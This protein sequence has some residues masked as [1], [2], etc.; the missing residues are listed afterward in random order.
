MM[1]LLPP[2]PSR[3]FFLNMASEVASP[4]T[5][6]VVCGLVFICIRATSEARILKAARGI[7]L[8]AIAGIPRVVPPC[9]R[10]VLPTSPLGADAPGLGIAEAPHKGAFRS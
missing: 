5:R 3:V 9:L 7:G 1:R 2:S 10:G 8:F 6:C 4:T